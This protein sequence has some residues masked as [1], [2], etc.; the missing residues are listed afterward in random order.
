M[1]CRSIW[2]LRMPRLRASKC[3]PPCGDNHWCKSY[4]RNRT[5]AQKVRCMTDFEI[6]MNHR[7]APSRAVPLHQKRNLHL[8]MKSRL[9]EK[10]TRMCCRRTHR[11]CQS[12]KHLVS[13]CCMWRRRLPKLPPASKVRKIPLVPASAEKKMAASSRIIGAAPPLACDVQSPKLARQ[14]AS[15]PLPPHPD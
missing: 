12:C 7:R 5:R 11:S 1:D 2:R 8:W 14:G 3:R 6:R 13:L 4:G 15:L 9:T 10:L